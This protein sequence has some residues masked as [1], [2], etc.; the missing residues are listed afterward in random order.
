MKPINDLTTHFE[1][2]HS[3]LLQAIGNGEPYKK[4][5]GT[6]KPENSDEPS[7]D[8]SISFGCSGCCPSAFK[9][10]VRGSVEGLWA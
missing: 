8:T 10:I 1:A 9:L 3:D 7:L 2:N 5:D 6:L 4:G